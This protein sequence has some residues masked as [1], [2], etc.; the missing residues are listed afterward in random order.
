MRLQRIRTE[1]PPA[2]VR[3]TLPG[4]LKSTLDAY[5]TYYHEQY[6]DVVGLEALVPQ[7]LT[8]FVSTDREFRAWQ[9]AQ[10]EEHAPQRS[11]TSPLIAR[12]KRSRSPVPSSQNPEVVHN[13]K[14][15][16]DNTL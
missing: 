2:R 12:S 5:A 11:P 8:T 13:G 1:L 6:G 4:D 7:I 10:T 15:M 16:N 14:P 9:Q 3:V